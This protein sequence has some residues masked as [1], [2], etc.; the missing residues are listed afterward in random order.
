MKSFICIFAVFLSINIFV[1]SIYYRVYHGTDK[2]I[3]AAPSSPFE[4]PFFSETQKGDSYVYYLY[5]LETGQTDEF[6][7]ISFLVGSA[8]C[9]VPASYNIEAIKA[10]MIAC[11][12]YYLYC[13]ENGLPDDDLNLS[14]DESRMQKYASKNRLKEFWGNGFDDNYKKFM[15]CAKEVR[16]IV[17]T[18][19]GKTALTPYYAVSCGTTQS[20]ENEWG[21]ALEYL[22]PVESR[23]DAL[24]DSYLKI[25]TFTVQEMYDRFIL[26]FAGLE[27]DME[28]PEEWIGD[29]SYNE[30]GYV[31]TVKINKNK[32]RGR[33]FRK[34]FELP[35]SCF[36]IFFEDNEFSIATKGY[37][38]G[39]GLSQFGS[40]QMAAEGK[41]FEEILNHYFP[42]TRLSTI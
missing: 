17:V 26:N 27:L 30:S 29:I 20:S 18:Y 14:Y 36:M 25:K 23:T 42:N 9:E 11:H 1:P 6:D 22:V 28:H 40:N 7:I 32:I 21:N 33:D 35:S 38:H 10:Q 15:E 2:S 31:D 8:A 41:N 24:S 5:N 37:G 12:S 4:S 39:V 34:Y 16:D 13:R 3:P 19:K